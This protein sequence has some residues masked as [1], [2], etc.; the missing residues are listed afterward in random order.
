MQMKL[1]YA[2]FSEQQ[3]DILSKKET[4]WNGHDLRFA[5]YL[6]MNFNTNTRAV[7][8]RKPKEIAD[9]LGFH[10]SFIYAA[11][12]K[13]NASGYAELYIK[14]KKI[15]G[16]LKHTAKESFADSE[17]SAEQGELDLGLTDKLTASMIDK[18]A[19]QLLI[20]SKLT[21]SQML[22]AFR[23]PL[24]CT[25][26][27]GEVDEIRTQEIADKISYHRTTVDRAI[28]TLNSIGYCQIE[29]DYT[30]SGRLP[31]T[32]YAYQQ[33]RTK[34]R[35]KAAANQNPVSAESF[36]MKYAKAAELLKKGYGIVSEEF[37]KS[38]A[39]VVELATLLTEKWI[40]K[41]KPEASTQRIDGL[42]PFGEAP[43]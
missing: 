4:D 30:L 17:N 36:A 25:L 43:A 42:L 32:A 41:W 1:D 13:M 28:D 26:K 16:K 15:A 37:L 35:A 29:R 33:N 20:E 2:L 18:N 5:A 34:K 8:R 40:P 27:T 10:P 21:P 23:L 24:H 3:I 14:N 31:F 38:K 9:E 19:I 6:Q 22:V 7:F 11:M 12:Q 39:E